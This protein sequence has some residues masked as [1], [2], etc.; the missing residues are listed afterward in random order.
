[1]KVMYVNCDET[2]MENDKLYVDCSYIPR[3]QFIGI[4]IEVATSLTI[5]IEL[6]F[7]VIVIK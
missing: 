6:I 4:L 3:S 2:G 1:M 7:V 5:I